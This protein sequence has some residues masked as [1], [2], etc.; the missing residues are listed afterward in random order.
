S[1]HPSTTYRRLER[2]VNAMMTSK[3]TQESAPDRIADTQAADAAA[4]RLLQ[5]LSG[6]ELTWPYK[7]EKL[8]EIAAGREI[9]SAE[10][11]IQIALIRQTACELGALGEKTLKK[12]GDAC[13]V[14]N[15]IHKKAYPRAA[16]SVT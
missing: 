11:A 16:A 13:D 14:A 1:D 3:P 2:Q 10:P 6:I 12:G 4:R 7:I 15:L 5:R 9:L 8:E